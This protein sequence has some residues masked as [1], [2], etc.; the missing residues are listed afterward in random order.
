LPAFRL[1]AAGV[2]VTANVAVA[3]AAA[4]VSAAPGPCPS[5]Y[6]RAVDVA[7]APQLQVALKQAKPGDQIRL[8]DGTYVGNFT[9]DVPGTASAPVVICG[10]SAAVISSGTTRIG[11]ALH[12]QDA[13]YTSIYGITLTNA[14]KGIVLDNSSHSVVDGVTVHDVGDE[15]VHF[16]EAT[17]DSV[18]RNSSVYNTG[19]YDPQYGEG[20]YVGSA[21]S[22]WCDYTNCAPDQADRNQ[23]LNNRVG[24]G[25]TAEA[26]DVKEG[27]TGGT[28]DG[29]TFD[30]S[31]MTSGTGATS[32]VDVKGNSWVISD[33][34][35]H[36]TLRNGFADSV[37]L[38]GWGS[39]NTFTNNTEYVNARGYGV[40]V[41]TSANDVKVTTSNTVYGAASGVSNIALVSG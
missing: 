39:D 28:I 24:P 16:R 14:Q 36:R 29:N 8:A 9:S 1:L 23:V 13:P 38:S 20:I 37:P 17:S 7:T 27:T 3:C 4:P 25:V 21:K 26:V 30:G 12:V 22:N 11:Y 40:L 34:V 33:N 35:G 15:G 10:S 2:L 18:I 19:L 41:A 31:G 6:V 32:W 5:S